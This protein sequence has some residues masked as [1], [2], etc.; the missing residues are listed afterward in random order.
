[1]L[2]LRQAV[3]RTGARLDEAAARQPPRRVAVLGVYGENQA[4]NLAAALRRLESAKHELLPTLGCLGRASPELASL[5]QIEQMRGGRQANLNR[6]AELG[7]ARESDWVLLI[8][9]DVVLGEQF[10]DRLL[11]LA[12]RFQLQLAQPALTRSSHTAWR[13]TRRRPCLLR[14]TGMVEMGPVV[15]MSREAFSELTPFPEQ[16]MGWGSCLHWAAVAKRRGWRLGI[17]DSV[18]ARHDQR[19]PGAAYDA[20]A[21]RAGA[22]AL[23]R[24]NEHLGWREA[25]RAF[26]TFK[27]L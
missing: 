12:E 17:A 23:L 2:A 1:M 13:V 16:G 24:E 9:D 15:L 6:L 10:L 27:K 7:Q 21:A 8:D 18:P 20:T 4:A 19:A 3:L 22:L 14:L 26:A 11:V 5:T 25:D